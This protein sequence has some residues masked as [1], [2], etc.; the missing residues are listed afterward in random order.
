MTAI[1]TELIRLDAI[2]KEFDSRWI[3]RDIT[4]VIPERGVFAITG[5]SGIGK[6][7]LSRI[8]VGLDP[9]SAGRV[10]PSR[11]FTVSAQFAEDRLL[12]S[13]SVERN[14]HYVGIDSATADPLADRLGMGDAMTAY[15]HELSSGMR[16]RAAFIR[17]VSHPADVLL[18]DEPFKGVDEAL[19]FALAAEI[20]H[21]AHRRV[22][23]LIDHDHSLVSE[24]AD[25]LLPLN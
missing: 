13:L 16:R 14:L 10:A 24:I 9:A 15:P 4:A 21:E 5:P 19:R 17:A 25:T 20:M 2:G 22:V 18:L 11:E 7:T 1:G 23:L 3:F 8:A 12:P 6:T